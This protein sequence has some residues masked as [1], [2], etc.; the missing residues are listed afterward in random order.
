[1]QK[2]KLWEKLY[3]LRR[4]IH[5]N[6]VHREQLNPVPSRSSRQ[7]SGDLFIPSGN[8]TPQFS[9]GK[10]PLHQS[11]MSGSSDSETVPMPEDEEQETRERKWKATSST[12]E[13]ANSWR[14]L[15]GTYSDAKRQIKQRSGRSESKRQRTLNAL[16]VFCGCAELSAQLTELG[17]ES[18]GVDYSFNKDRPRMTCFNVDLSTAEGQKLLWQMVEG[19]KPDYVHFAPLCGTASRARER[20]ISKSFSMKAPQPL[21]SDQ[22]PDGLEELSPE[23]RERVQAVAYMPSLQWQSSVQT[24]WALI[25]RLRTHPTVCFGQLPGWLA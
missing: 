19:N 7:G 16:E 21:R 22:H 8:P 17:I 20:P 3:A 4:Q 6:P 2:T 18:V 24:G 25:G 13:Q 9:A 12:G 5:P 23:D 1:M 11:H 15:L 14:V 10:A